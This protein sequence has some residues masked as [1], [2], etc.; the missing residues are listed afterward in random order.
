MDQGLQSDQTD[1]DRQ[2][3]LKL[4]AGHQSMVSFV[5][6]VRREMMCLCAHVYTKIAA[7]DQC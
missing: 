3:W 4:I 5:W 2:G 6:T 1:L 7:V